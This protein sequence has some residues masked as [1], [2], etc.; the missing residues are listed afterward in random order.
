MAA[1]EP[2]KASLQRVNG[3]IEK[4]SRE[5]SDLELEARQL[6]QIAIRV[7]S[8]PTIRDDDR[9]FL[10]KH[11]GD[12]QRLKS[13]E[14]QPAAFQREYGSGIALFRAAIAEGQKR[15]AN[16]GARSVEQRA[17]QD[18]E[19]TDRLDRAKE[20]RQQIKKKEADL[21]P[22]LLEAT[23]LEAGLNRVDFF[24]NPKI[25]EACGM[26]ATSV[27]TIVS[28]IAPGVFASYGGIVFGLQMLKLIVEADDAQ[29]TTAGKIVDLLQ[30]P[31]IEKGVLKVMKDG[32][33]ASLIGSRIDYLIEC[34]K[35]EST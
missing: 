34:L 23:R 18:K 35:R 7:L 28:L 20:M 14:A 17:R 19:A 21:T 27:G 13:L 16:I 6:K 9:A 11:A 22:L 32:R 10:T 1:L 33:G 26:L 29:T 15:A 4:L 2:T 24:K 8:A 3:Q 5:I 31:L 25:A 30:G 12:L